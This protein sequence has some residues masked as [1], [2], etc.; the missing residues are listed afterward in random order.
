MSAVSTLFEA[1]FSAV[2]NTY[3]IEIMITYCSME[4]Y[5]LASS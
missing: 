1:Q 2:L 3:E 5:S 4:A